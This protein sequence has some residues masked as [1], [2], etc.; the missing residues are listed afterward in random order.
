MPPFQHCVWPRA[1]ARNCIFYTDYRRLRINFHSSLEKLIYPTRS[2]TKNNICIFWSSHLW[3]WQDAILN[4]CVDYELNQRGHGQHNVTHQ[5]EIKFNFQ[6]ITKDVKN[7]F[8]YRFVRCT[9]LITESFCPK[10]AQ[11]ITMH[12]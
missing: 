6:V 9:T 12:S 10:Q 2:P 11:L 5:E 4:A 7:G 1:T 8:F 3:L